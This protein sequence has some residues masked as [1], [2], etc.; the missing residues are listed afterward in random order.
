MRVEH[1]GRL[2]SRRVIGGAQ[3]PRLVSQPQGD[4][5]VELQDRR[6]RDYLAREVRAPRRPTGGSRGC[7]VARLRAYQ[8]KTTARS[9]SSCS[10]PSTRRR[11]DV[12]D[13]GSR[14]GRRA[15]SAWPSRRAGRTSVRG[16]P[17]RSPVSAPSR[18]S[19]SRRSRTGR[20]AGP[21]AGGR[22]AP[23][24]PRGLACRGRGSRGPPG[25]EGRRS[26]PVPR[27]SP[28]LDASQAAGHITP[29]DLSVQANMMERPTVWPAMAEAYRAARGGASPIG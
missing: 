2:R 18:R 25:R 5:R 17:G 8:A 28:G 14:S 4:P 23:R 22:P 7:G 19:P 10:S 29:T 12:L 6:K 26:G 27:H 13:R 20:W 16:C 15:S 9:R 1:D 21:D 3:K 11:H 24:G